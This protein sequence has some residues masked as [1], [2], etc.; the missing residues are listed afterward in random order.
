MVDTRS[1]KSTVPQSEA[2]QARIAAILRERKEKKELLK[3]A[4]VKAIAEEKVTKKKKLEEEMLRFQKEKMMMLEREEEEKRKVA[5]EEA[6]AEEEEEEEEEPLER[7]R[8]EERGEASGTKGEDAWMDRKISEW[9]ANFSL[10]EDE[11]ALL[12]VSQEER[13]AFARV[14]ETIEDPLERQTTEDEKKLEWKLRMMREKKRRREEANRVARE[15]ERVRACRP[16]MQAQTEVPAKLDKIIGEFARDVVTHVGAEVK[17]LKEG[18]EKFCVGAIEGA[19]V[20]ATTEAAVHPRKEPVKLKFLDAYSGKK[21]ESFDKWEA[22]LNTYVY[23]QHIAP[24]EQVL[25]A[26]HALKDEAASFARSLARTADCEHNM[27]AYYRLTPLS[28][29][30]KLLRERFADVTRGVRASD[31]LQTIHSRQWRSARALKAVMDDLVAVLEKLRDAN[32]KIN[33][34]KC[35]WAKTQVLYLGHVLDGDGIKP[36]DGKIAAIRD[37]PT[38]RT[39][40]ELR[41]FLGLANY[42]RKFVRNFSTIAAP[43]RRLLKKEAIWQWD[44][45]CTSALKKL[46]RALIEYLVLKVVD[47]SLPFVVTTDASQYGI[48]VVLQPDDG[49]DYRPVEFMSARMPSEKVATSTYEREL[50]A[51]RQALEHWKHYLLGRHFKV[52]SDHETLRW[53][54]TQAKMTPRLTR[55]PPGT[56]KFEIQHE[57][58]IAT[59]VEN[60]RKVQHQMIEQANKHRRPSQFQVGDLVWVKSNEFAPEENISQKLLPAYRGPWP[61]LEVK[62]GEDGPSYTVEISAHLHTYPVFHALKLLPCV[63]S[64]QFPSRRSMIPPDMDRRYDIDG[65]VGEDVFRTGGRGHPQKQNKVRFAYQESEDDRW[66][67]R[68]ELLET[69]PDIVRAYERD[70]KGKGPALD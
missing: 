8:R 67:T 3:Q 11:E 14:L 28:T 56:S 6:A 4:K 61:V 9:V 38:P 58:E 59:V 63:T 1:G 52:Y 12:Y 40:I 27:I 66:F 69:A 31:K 16:E 41:S 15:V 68:A 51:L 5:E 36:E 7:R 25:V 46:K 49:N 20:V 34:K 32:F 45:D 47:Q 48:G 44:K 30:L 65:I 57:K 23:L 24:E 21:D 42:Y 55:L 39:L 2:K 22:S 62:G 26:F 29:F 60:L 50:Y 64:Q 10:G 37:W 70:K 13:E 43:L 17:K 53:L 54:K 18:A 19:K 35:E 33:A